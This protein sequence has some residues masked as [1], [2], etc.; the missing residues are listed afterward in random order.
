MDYDYDDD[1]LMSSCLIYCPLKIYKWGS[2]ITQSEL[3]VTSRRK[4]RVELNNF[5]PQR[6]HMM[7]LIIMMRYNEV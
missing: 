7:P 4:T 3:I 2:T 5:I 1:G 6:I